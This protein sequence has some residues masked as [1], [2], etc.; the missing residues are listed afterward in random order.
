[1]SLLGVFELKG[2]P[3]IIF[4][5]PDISKS[6]E[7]EVLEVLRSGWL[8]TGQ[9]CHEFEREFQEF[10]GS[11][12]AVAVNSCTMGLY[13]SLRALDIGPGDEVILPPL[14]FS[15][16]LNSIFMSGAKPVFV[17]VDQ[18]GQ[19]D[20]D[21]IGHA[22]TNKTKAIIPVHYTGASCDMESIRKIANK[23]G[24][25]VIEDAAHAFGGRD[26]EGFR[27]GAYSDI[28][29]FSFYAT[30]NITSG[31]G[32][33]V[34]AKDRKIADRIRVLS[35]NG[36]DADSWK[37]YGDSKIKEY[38][39]KEV[40]FKGNMSDIHAAVGLVQIKRW[41]FM[42]SRRDLIW[43]I[44]SQAFGEREEGHSTHL[45]TILAEDRDL[46]RKTLFEKGIGTGI[47]FNPLHLEPAYKFLGHMKN[48]FMYAEFIG[49]HTLSLPVS[50]TMNEKDAERVVNTVLDAKIN[51]LTEVR[52][53]PKI[54][55]EKK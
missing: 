18:N 39:V 3:F 17:D 1:M 40:G 15:A 24:I 14:T 5:K 46:L 9:K 25:R 11:G 34:L 20:P 47:H 53:K 28:A 23:H 12:N 7:S 4:C 33:I 35:S 13:L 44:Y 49:A 27:I 54:K 32:G 21:E 45:Y 19:I 50:S 36:L 10:I 38:R 30:K 31:E 51:I 43:D 22:C 55:G 8:S 16:T 2:D 41:P 26:D 42:K 52:C 6:E 37:R 48:D 29:C